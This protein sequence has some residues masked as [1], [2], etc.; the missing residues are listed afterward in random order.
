MELKHHYFDI[1]SQLD[2]KCEKCTEDLELESLKMINDVIEDTE[3]DI[4]DSGNDEESEDSESENENEN[5]FKPL[6]IYDDLCDFSIILWAIKNIIP[7]QIRIMFELCHKYRSTFLKENV[8]T[9]VFHDYQITDQNVSFM[10]RSIK[11]TENIMNNFSNSLI[12][13]FNKLVINTRNIIEQSHNVIF[14]EKDENESNIQ[15]V[16]VAGGYPSN[17]IFG[18]NNS[19]LGNIDIWRFHNTQQRYKYVQE[20]SGIFEFSEY[21]FQEKSITF[22]FVNSCHDSLEKCISEFDM[23][24]CQIGIL[25]KKNIEE[26]PSIYVTPMFLYGYYTS[27]NITKIFPLV[28]EY[29]EYRFGDYRENRFDDYGEYRLEY[30]KSVNLKNMF[31]THVY[32]MKCGK[33]KF[34]GHDKMTHSTPF[35]KCNLCL[36]AI[37]LRKYNSSKCEAATRWMKRVTKYENRYPMIN[38]EFIT[39]TVYSSIKN[40]ENNTL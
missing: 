7:E 9:N 2:C 27:K 3:S 36:E 14:N 18:E 37:I 29:I 17:C 12:E 34:V 28:L 31:K 1:S 38:V 5:K 19:I 16:F 22:D 39:N 32:E 15:E 26:E 35:N 4:Q 33:S 10:Y 8:L 24:V 11:L 20:K 23:S 6:F 30:H 21:S 25:I 13:K 40:Y